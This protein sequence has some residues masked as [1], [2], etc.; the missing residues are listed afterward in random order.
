[1]SESS[2]NACE[3]LG[4]VSAGAKT[5]FR[6]G[7][8]RGYIS[9]RRCCFVVVRVEGEFCVR[10]CVTVRSAER[11]PQNLGI[12]SRLQSRG[13]LFVGGLKLRSVWGLRPGD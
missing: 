4:T 13:K 3:L 9:A 11:R 5:H 6:M 2:V 7:F 10:V 12:D 1:M 8:P